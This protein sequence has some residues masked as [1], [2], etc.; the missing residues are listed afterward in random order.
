[1]FDA[2]LR[3]VTVYEPVPPDIRDP[4][5]FSRR[6]GPETDPDL[7]LQQRRAQLEESAPR[8]V[9]L[10]SIPDPVSVAAGLSDHLAERPALILVAGGE[11]HRSLFA[12]GVIRVLLR[13]LAVPVLLVPGAAAHASAALDPGVA[14]VEGTEA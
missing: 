12:P 3:L 9:D 2:P 7:Y 4:A 10:V 11:H 5:H 6:R 13:T 8:G 14:D 1:L